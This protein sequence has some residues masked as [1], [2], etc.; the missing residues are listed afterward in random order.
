MKIM[1]YEVEV[2][3]TNHYEKIFVFSCMGTWSYLFSLRKKKNFILSNR[4]FISHK[5]MNEKR[6]KGTNIAVLE[7]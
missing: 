5:Q 7:G 2:T 4:S 3:N 6:K 1:F